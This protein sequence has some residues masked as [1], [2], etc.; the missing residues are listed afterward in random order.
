MNWW[1]FRTTRWSPL[2]FG[3]Y[4]FRVK[5][6]LPSRTG[7]IPFRSSLG[8]LSEKPIQPSTRDMDIY[9]VAIS[10]W[11]GFQP[12]NGE[13]LVCTAGYTGTDLWSDA[14][15][16]LGKQSTTVLSYHWLCN[17]RWA[18]LLSRLIIWG[19]SSCSSGA[20]K[21]LRLPETFE[22]LSSD[23]VCKGFCC[24]YDNCNM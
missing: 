12:Q 7:F 13:G 18:A 10:G 1:G 4:H 8:S 22:R 14:L 9:I 2:V 6:G 21:P 23:S 19:S 17:L 11:A 20:S 24:R 3:R 5:R 16:R 15:N